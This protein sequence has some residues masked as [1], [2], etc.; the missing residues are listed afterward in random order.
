MSKWIQKVIDRSQLAQLYSDHAG[1]WL[2]LEIM[3]RNGNDHPKKFKLI[4]LDSDKEKLHEYLLEDESWDW[5]KK[6]LMIFADPEKPC[7]IK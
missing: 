4:S 3:E 5:S 7:T 2:L 6:Y 1:K